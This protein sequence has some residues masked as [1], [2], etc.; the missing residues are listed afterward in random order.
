MDMIAQ[1]LNVPSITES[2]PNSDLMIQNSNDDYVYV[3]ANLRTMIEDVMPSVKIAT[4]ELQTNPTPRILESVSVLL[5]TITEMNKDL[6]NLSM[7]AKR[8]VVEQNITTNNAIFTGSIEEL[9][10]KI[11]KRDL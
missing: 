11:T 8:D 7:P 6:L 4:N 10:S 9:I 5:K 3:R 1:T 2:V